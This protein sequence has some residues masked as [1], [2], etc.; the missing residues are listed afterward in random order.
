MPPFEFPNDR[1]RKALDDLRRGVIDAP[2]ARA[3]AQQP[4][5]GKP[6]G[7]LAALFGS[8]ALRRGDDA[9]LEEIRRECELL[10]AAPFKPG[11]VIG[12]RY[13]VLKHFHGGFGM[14][15]VCRALGPER[16]A[17]SGNLCALKTP[18]PRHLA[19]P[20]LRESFLSEAARCV[21]LGPHPNLVLCYGLEEHNRLPFLVLEYVPDAR[22]LHDEV[23]AGRVDWR[24][25]LKVALGVARGLAFARLV[26]GDLKPVN[27]LLGAGDAAKVADFGLSL[28]EGEGS[29][30]GV[31]AGT[32]GFMAPEMLQ[33]RPARTVA[34]DVYAFGVTLFAAATRS[35]PFD[36]ADP[37]AGAKAP[38]PDPRSAN[39]SL[40]SPLAKLIL[41]CLERD[42]SA[43]PASFASLARELAALHKE[44]LGADPVPDPEPDAPAR[45]NAL[46]N[47][48]QTY[49]D[50]GRPAKAA[51]AANE[52]VAADPGNWKARNAVGLCVMEAGK[53]LE[54][55][56]HF[57]QAAVLAPLEL[58]PGVN[59]AQG[60]AKA[61]DRA[62][63]ADHLGKAWSLAVEHDRVGEL[64]HA[65]L[66]ALEL[67][68]ERDAYH[69]VHAV[70]GANPT[71]AVT[72][73][74]RAILM[75][76]MEAF[77]EA[78][79]SAERA[80][81]LNPTYAKAYVQKANALVCLGRN[82]EALAAAERAIAL[83]ATLAGAHAAKFS[84]LATLGRGTEA[85][86]AVERGLSLLPG[87]AL[88]LKARASLG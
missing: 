40:P 24:R 80:L 81:G 52:A 74:N 45:A 86:A 78:L 85:R 65:S 71:A 35:L 30:E 88:L 79:S 13:Q 3:L 7:K 29:E 68:E 22:N 2:T 77:D 59:L 61:G 23:A 10:D 14:V 54:A 34:T 26:H 33:G 62:R 82:E 5:G 56:E 70:L 69:F 20:E 15:Y 39:P 84:A 48:A 44:L 55:V 75:R 64:D 25:A 8:E 21:A 28:G 36:P 38:A 87:N 27:I 72:W 11:D 6:P 1:L 57:L 4:V 66:L 37:A 53:P 41:R 46:V 76:R 50:L 12:S 47:L 63:A 9:A 16:Y 73:N 51:Q 17:R 83:D 60:Y 67:L 42:P 32:R 49:L 43:R 58:V 19:S 18:L 31:L